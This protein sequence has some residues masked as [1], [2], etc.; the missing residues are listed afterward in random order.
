LQ[1]FRLDSKGIN[2]WIR[3]YVKQKAKSPS[4]R[5]IERNLAA[6]SAAG[7][8]AR[9]AGEVETVTVAGGMH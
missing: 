9:K 5:E 4:E 3:R 2:G 7:E 1:V 6:N 8:M